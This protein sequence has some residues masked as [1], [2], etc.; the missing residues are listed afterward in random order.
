MPITLT[1][2]R[3]SL[4]KLEAIEEKEISSLLPTWTLKFNTLGND[5]KKAS[6]VY[7]QIF[8]KRIVYEQIFNYLISNKI[9]ADG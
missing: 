1:I 2:V 4:S 9:I 5:E 7:Y 3:V 6:S 8:L